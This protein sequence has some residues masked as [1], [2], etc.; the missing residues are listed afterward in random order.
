MSDKTLLIMAA[1]LGSRFGG[2]KQIASLGPDGEI[3]MD[4]SIHDAVA[5]GFNK[6]V[7]VIKPDMKEKF[8]EVIG[9]RI[10][11][12]VKV[13]YA[14]QSFDNLPGGFMAQE[15]RVKPYGTVHAVLSAKDVVKEPFAVINADDFYGADAFRTIAAKLDAMRDNE[16]MQ[17]CMVAYYLKNTVSENGAVTRGVCSVNKDGK[18]EKVTETYKIVT[19]PDGTI[20]DIEKNSDGDMLDLHDLVSMNFW[21]FLPSVFAAFEEYMIE[22]MKALK[23]EEIKKECL[24][25]S[26][27][28]E[29]M[30]KGKMDVTVLS[31]ADSWIGVTYPDDK[32]I[33]MN[34]LK[35]M[36]DDGIYP[37]LID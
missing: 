13:D 4:Y 3:L 20:R 14:F 7:F 15:G 31:S 30:H 36:H 25:P 16:K 18:L 35:K 12:K 26:F 32:F 11:K 37:N 29:M 1:G 28:D 10:S 27:V 21:G 33:V 24:L 34:A 17:A 2:D 22:F 9:D 23:P 19:F 5:A 6:V 8:H